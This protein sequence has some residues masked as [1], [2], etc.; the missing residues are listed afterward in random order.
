MSTEQKEVTLWELVELCKDCKSYCHEKTRRVVEDVGHRVWGFAWRFD[1]IAQERRSE[2]QM[3]CEQACAQVQTSCPA[4]EDIRRAVEAK[5]T[6]RP[7]GADGA[8]A[9]SD[10]ALNRQAGLKEYSMTKDGKYVVD[11]TRA[12]ALA[13]GL[14]GDYIKKDGEDEYLWPEPQY[15]NKED[16]EGLGAA[17]ANL[18]SDLVLR[19]C[20]NAADQFART[21]F[22]IATKP[23]KV[24]FER[25]EDAKVKSE[26]MAKGLPVDHVPSH[27]PAKPAQ[28]FESQW[29]ASRVGRGGMPP[30]KMEDAV[31]LPPR[32]QLGNDDGTGGTRVDVARLPSVTNQ[33]TG[34]VNLKSSLGFPAG[35]DPEAKMRALKIDEE[36]REEM[37]AWSRSALEGIEMEEKHAARR[38]EREAAAAA[39]AAA[40]PKQ[41]K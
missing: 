15:T 21:L 3:Q 29:T 39:A 8:K 41:Q 20:E 14:L 25:A 10:E 23:T 30:P 13:R 36:K 12:N 28:N 27:P 2:E 17:R 40:A 37:K 22:S 4:A 18:P 9:V 26:Y 33:K 34:E 35:T 19:R 16:K 1:Q 5:A 24:F 11:K 31:G 38:R 6:V 32:Q 7:L